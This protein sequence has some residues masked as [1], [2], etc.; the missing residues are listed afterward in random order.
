[1]AAQQSQN[2]LIADGST[3]SGHTCGLECEGTKNDTCNKTLEHTGAADNRNVEN[4]EHQQA[5]VQEGAQAL[6]THRGRGG[7]GMGQ[8][9]LKQFCEEEGIELPWAIARLKYQGFPAQETMT[10]R[11]IAGRKGAHPRE[12]RD[13]L[14]KGH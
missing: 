10:M 6:E 4:C 14:Q 13:I 9:T 5:G 11:E 8:K 1:M 7:G 12:L 3:L 2:P